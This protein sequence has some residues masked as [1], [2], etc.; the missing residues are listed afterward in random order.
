MSLSP[1][2]SRSWWCAGSWRTTSASTTRSTTEWR[3]SVHL[4]KSHP[5][6]SVVIRVPL[7]TS[8]RSVCRLNYSVLIMIL[9]MSCV[10][11]VR[12]SGL[13]RPWKITP[14]TRGRISTHVSSW[15]KQ[16]HTTN[17]GTLLRYFSYSSGF[18]VTCSP[19]C[20]ALRFLLL[21]ISYHCLCHYILFCMFFI[22]ILFYFYLYLFIYS[23]FS[24]HY[25]YF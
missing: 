17:S 10:S 4:V 11:Q 7:V 25:L 22:F 1:P 9:K 20:V 2:S 19:R 12:M 14:K 13:R 5:V 16:R 24:S 21:F 15:R 18:D 3:V 6:H 8:L 23:S